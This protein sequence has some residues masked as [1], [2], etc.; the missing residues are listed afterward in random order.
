VKTYTQEAA[1]T[2]AA[3]VYSGLFIGPLSDADFTRTIRMALDGGASGVSLFD[4]GAMTP[5][6]WALFARTVRSGQAEA[7]PYVRS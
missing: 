4:A 6:R 3:P 5:E 2:V 1:R 7:W